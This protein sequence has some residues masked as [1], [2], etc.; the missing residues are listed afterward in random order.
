MMTSSDDAVIVEMAGSVAT[1]W[2]NRPERLNAWTSEMAARYFGLMEDA[3]ADPAV[4]VIVITGAGRGFCAGADL[5]QLKSEGPPGSFA[6]DE[7]PQEVFHTMDIPKPVIAAI[8]G[9]CVGIALVLAATCDLRF[10]A[11]GA[12][13]GTI[14]ARLGLIAEAGSSWLL[15]RL[16]GRGAALDILLSGRIFLAEEALQLRFVDRVYPAERLLD[17]TMAYAREMAAMCSPTSLAIIK[18]QVQRN[19]EGSFLAAESEAIRMVLEAVKGAD[20]TEGMASFAEK[21]P[22]RFAPLRR[23]P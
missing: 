4:K 23:D 15:P 18:R 9:A 6:G 20:F 2:M 13:F 12:K 19:A 11:A 1:I 14:F 3:A 21:R 5:G 8:N 7:R 22:P 17:E 16:M 10:A